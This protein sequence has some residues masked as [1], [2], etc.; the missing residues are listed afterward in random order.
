MLSPL[1]KLC[2]SAVS[3]NEGSPTFAVFGE[4]LVSIGVG[5]ATVIVCE[6]DTPVPLSGAGFSTVTLSDP[7]VERSL[8]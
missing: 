7:F 1:T 4:I 6:P 2:P 3:V 8:A 5:V